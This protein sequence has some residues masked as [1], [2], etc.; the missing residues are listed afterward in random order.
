[1]PATVAFAKCADYSRDLRPAV[2]Q[3]LAHLGGIKAFVKPGQSV[4]VKPNML[5]DATPDQ[6]KTTHPAVVRPI[7]RIL[8]DLGAKP[9]VADSPASVLK[10]HRVWERTGFRELCEEEGVPLLSL[11]EGGAQSFAAGK[12]SFSIARR[13]IDADVIISVP[14]VKTHGLTGFTGGV[15][16]MYGCIPGLQKTSMHRRYFKPAQFGKLVSLVYE[17]ARPTLT[18]I[19]GIVG[20]EGNGPAAGDLVPLGFLA[21]ST[22]AAALDASLCDILGIPARAVPYFDAIR[23]TGLGETRIDQINLVGAARADIVPATFRPPNTLPAR[24]VPAWLVGLLG[25]VLWCRPSF[26]DACVGC[27][28]CVDACPVD[29]L[30]LEPKA[31]PVLDADKCVDCCCCLEVCPENAI[32]MK[33]GAL[34]RRLFKK[35][36]CLRT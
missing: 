5:T 11:E 36:Q 9:F 16:N 6:G 15:K 4:L 19:D 1:M 29:A 27:G 13:V 22:D 3:I 25:P 8:K 10:L 7:L 17:Q 28:L 34:L 31:K 30:S 32:D 20:M 18:I 23:K 2:E 14:K 26:S 33:L 24:L 12:F 35:D 21:G